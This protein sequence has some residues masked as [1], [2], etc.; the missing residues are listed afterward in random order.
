MEHQLF[1]RGEAVVEIVQPFAERRNRVCW[2]YFDSE[3]SAQLW[4]K[5]VEDVKILRQRGVVIRMPERT[6]NVDRKGR[7]FIAGPKHMKVK[8]I[9]SRLSG[10][11]G[12][13]YSKPWRRKHYC[14]SSKGK[15][16][17]QVLGI[18]VDQELKSFAI[19]D[20]SYDSI[21]HQETF[22]IL[23]HLARRGISL[24]SSGV[25]VSNYSANNSHH[26][27]SGTEI[28]LVGYD[29]ER[30][31]FVIIEIKVT[32][33]PINYL[34]QKNKD[35]PLVRSCGFRRSEMGRYAAQVACTL[36]MYIN[37]FGAHQHY[38]LLVICESDTALCESFT[39][40]SSLVDASRFPMIDGF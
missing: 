38:P 12:D 6:L 1:Y 40:D 33:K 35:A 11:F 4:M 16:G 10:V 14:K 26:N 18:S 19:G 17:M 30:K 8:G 23:Q 7:S 22:S 25:L 2:T 31:S 32:G 34:K 36:L 37:T 9:T 39:I 21:Q 3:E 20:L 24:I 28:D 13:L 5:G 15:K 29:H 27:Y